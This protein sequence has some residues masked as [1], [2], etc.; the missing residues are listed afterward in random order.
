MTLNSDATMCSSWLLTP[1]SVFLIRNNV[2]KRLTQTDTSTIR[3]VMALLSSCSFALMQS[4]FDDVVKNVIQLIRIMKRLKLL[5]PNITH[6]ITSTLIRKRMANTNTANP[7]QNSNRCTALKFFRK[8][9]SFEIV[10]FAL[11]RFGLY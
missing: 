6:S 4:C 9:Y 8:V 3:N 11:T 2:P 10:F 7:K 1:S 5:H